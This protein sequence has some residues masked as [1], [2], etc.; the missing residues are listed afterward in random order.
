MPAKRS[1][2]ED[3]LEEAVCQRASNEPS[4]R[5]NEAQVAARVVALALLAPNWVKRVRCAFNSSTGWPGNKRA[6]LVIA[7]SERASGF[8]NKLKSSAK[9][10]TLRSVAS[11]LRATPRSAS[12]TPARPNKS[13]NTGSTRG[14]FRISAVLSDL[15]KYCKPAGLFCASGRPSATAL[16]HCGSNCRRVSLRVYSR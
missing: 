2:R 13:A 10:E 1:A 8:S 4:T 16:R 7:S 12:S 5:A 14:S 11:S 3:G 9:R 15:S 6:K